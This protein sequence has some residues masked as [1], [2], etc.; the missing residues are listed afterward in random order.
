MTIIRSYNKD[1]KI[2]TSDV[3][4]K[5]VSHYHSYHISPFQ[6]KLILITKLQYL[7]QVF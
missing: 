6:F 7:D 5:S 3:L 4:Y 2:I 1:T